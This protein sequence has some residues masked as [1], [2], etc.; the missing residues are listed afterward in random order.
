MVTLKTISDYLERKLY[1]ISAIFIVVATLLI[2]MEIFSRNILVRSIVWS[3]EVTR[4][5]TISAV[6]LL[7]GPLT[8]RGIHINV[9][10][11]YNRLPLAIAKY[12]SILV[13]CLGISMCALLTI[14]GG[15][16]M[17]MYI[18]TKSKSI[19]GSALHPWVWQ[20]P[21]IVG[22][23]VATFY[24]CEQLILNLKGGQFIQQSK[25]SEPEIKL[26]EGI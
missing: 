20:F 13:C 21:L 24:F 11:I 6:F 15:R 16:L 9:T 5:L 18:Q 1:A 12:A 25:P 7:V 22:M 26:G 10:L 8:K 19:T 23:G 3:E 14:W 2:V 4:Y 17:A